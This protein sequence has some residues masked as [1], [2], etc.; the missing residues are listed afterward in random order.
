MDRNTSIDN[1]TQ[2]VFKSLSARRA[3]IEIPLVS[4]P[5]RAVRVALRKESVDRNSCFWC[6]FYLYEG[7]LSARRAWI[8]IASKE[9]A[10]QQREVALRKESVDRNKV[11]ALRETVPRVALRKESVDRNMPSIGTFRSTHKSLSARRAW[12][13]MP[14]PA[15]LL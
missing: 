13:E 1:L 2:G 6:I 4:L 8:E 11:S 15:P 12:I 5:S 9:N 10:T 7:S 3:W 14:I